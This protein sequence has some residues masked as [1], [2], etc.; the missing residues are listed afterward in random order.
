LKEKYVEH[1]KLSFKPHIHIQHL[2]HFQPK[3][4]N[5]GRVIVTYFGS[6]QRWWLYDLHFY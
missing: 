3:Y 6:W 2:T 5:C 1:Q 4:S